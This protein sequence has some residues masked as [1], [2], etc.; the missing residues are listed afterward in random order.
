LSC[1]YFL[2]FVG[3]GFGLCL[4]SFFVFLSFYLY[5]YG[6]VV[7]SPSTPLLPKKIKKKKEKQK[8]KE[9]IDQNILQQKQ[10]NKS[11]TKQTKKKK[12]KNDKRKAKRNS[13]YLL[14]LERVLCT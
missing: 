6:V 4:P 2:V 8:E 14:P 1:F 10:E 3:E 11:K 7:G 5:I 12:E 9:N 13:D